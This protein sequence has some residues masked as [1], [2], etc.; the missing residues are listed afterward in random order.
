VLALAAAISLP[1]TLANGTP[2]PHRDLIIFL[3]FS[4][5][6]VTLVFQGLTLPPVIRALGLAGSSGG[7][8]EQG[9]RRLVLEAALAY[10]EQNRRSDSTGTADVFDDLARHYQRRLASVSRPS[11]D[12]EI[13]N[14]EHY[15]QHLDVSREV[16]DVERRTALRLRDE[17]RIT[18]ETLRE[19]EHEL[20]LSE[21][22]IAASLHV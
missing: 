2:F 21:A 7:S 8:A 10:L 5:I 17:G 12:V 15:V 9:A 4:V 20:D 16:I 11:A 22:R 18:D 3:T 19:I 1:E 13:G 6:L 14:P